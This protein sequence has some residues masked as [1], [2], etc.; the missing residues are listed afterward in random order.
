MYDSKLNGYTFF[1]SGTEP[2][3]YFDMVSKETNTML[4]SY[5]YIRN[6]GVKILEERY[7]K[8]PGLKILLDS[9]AF[10]FNTSEE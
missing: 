7:E 3:D 2:N 8:C 9:G 1:F 4:M 6:K 5:L 10:T